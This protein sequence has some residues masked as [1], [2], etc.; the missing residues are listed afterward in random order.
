MRAHVL[1]TFVYVFAAFVASPAATQP[2]MKEAAL[3]TASIKGGGRLRWPPP[4]VD[5]FIDTC[6]GVGEA[7]DAAESYANVCKT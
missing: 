1:H 2:F 6:V 7:T 4:F 5:S 3:R